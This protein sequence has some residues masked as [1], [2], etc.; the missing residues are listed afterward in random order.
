VVTKLTGLAQSDLVRSQKPGIVGTNVA[1]LYQDAAKKAATEAA[2]F[3][4][5]KQEMSAKIK[6]VKL[7]NAST[8][9]LSDQIN[10]NM[11][12]LF[13]NKNLSADAFGKAFATALAGQS[14][15]LA[16]MINQANGGK[17]GT[18]AKGP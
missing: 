3:E 10:K 13:D 5:L 17:H 14:K 8:K 18:G 12:A 16:A 9:N 15:S 11:T 6:N 7:D 2:L 4:A 1:A